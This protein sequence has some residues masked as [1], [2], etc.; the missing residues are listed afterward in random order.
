MEKNG[1]SKQ[2]KRSLPESK[3]SDDV[4]RTTRPR[5]AAAC[6]DFKEKSLRFSEKSDTIETKKQQVVEDEFLALG[7]TTLP[8]DDPSRSTRRLTDFILHDSHGVSQPVEMLEITD[9]FISGVILPSDECSDK[10]KEKGVRCQSFGRV[11]HWSISGYEDGSPVIWISTEL[12]DYDCRKPNASYKKIYD[13]FFLKA[14][15]SIAVYKRLSKSAGGDPDTSLEELLAAVV[16]SMID[17]KYFSSS[18]AVQDFVIVQGEFIYNQLAGLDETAKKHETNFAEI[19]V[20][21]IL[22]DENSRLDK[23]VQMEGNPSNGSL[24]IDGVSQVAEGET[25]TTD[26]LVDGADEDR[27][28]A[29][30][31]QDEEYRKS[32]QRPRKNSSTASASKNVYIKIDED[33]IANDYPLPSYYKTSKEETDELLLSDAGYEVDP[34][35]LPRRTL[36]NWALYNSDSRLISLE[37][38]PTKACDN[39]DVTIFGS[40]VVTDDDGIWFSLDDTGSAMGSGSDPDGMNIFLSQI[41]EWM[42][43]FGGEFIGISLRTDMA[44][45]RLGKPLKHYAPWFEPVLKSA[46]VGISIIT[47]LED[48]T[49]VAK[50]LFPEIMKRLSVVQKT[51]KA[52]ISSDSRT[53]ERYVVA[54]GQIISLVF[55]VYPKEKIRRS[56]FVTELASKMEQRNHTRWNIKKKK[57]LQKGLNLNP[58]AAMAP[59]VSKRKAMRAT[60]TCL[61]NRIWGEYFSI[62]SPEDS[63]QEIAA[64]NGEEEIEEEG[65]NEEDDN[66]DAEDTVP[67]PVEVQKSRTPKKIR[68]S[69]EEMEIKWDGVILGKTSAGEPLYG[70]ALVGGEVVAVGGAVILEIDDPNEFPAIYF[71]EYMFES[72]DHC[73]MLHGRLL[74]R[75]SE[76]VL[77]NAA[78]E[79]ELFLTNECMTVQLKDLKG[80]VSF[81]IRSR[82]WGHQYRKESITEDKLDRARAKERKAKDLPIEYFC[83]SLYSPERGG[84]FSLPLNDIGRGS[85]FCN[86]CKIREDEDE[87]AKIKLNVSKTGFSSNGIEYSAEDFVYVNPNFITIDGLKDSRS[88]FKSGQNIGLRAFVICQLLEIIPNESK[89]AELGSFEVKVRRFYRPED[90][91]EDK[92]YTSDIQEVYYSQDTNVLLPGALEGKCEVRKKID[93]PLRREYPISDHIFFCELFYDSSNGSLK[94]LPANMKLKFST[95]KDDTLLR[96]KKGKGVES[97]TDSGIVKPD[98]VPKEMRLAT[99]DIFAGCGGLSHGLKMAGVSDTKWAIEYEEPAGQAFRQN[100]PE[101]TVFVDNCNVIL[102]AIME[103][104]GDQDE[105]ISTKEANELAAKL[106]EDQKSTLPLPG[107][108]DFINGGP[109]CQ[110]FSGMNRFNESSWSKVQCEMILAFLSFAD[111]FRPRYFLLENVRTFVSFNKGQTFQLTVASLLEMG[112]QVRFGILEAGAYGISQARKRAFIWAAAPEEV[113]PEWP[114]PM[115]V[116]GVPKLNISLSR[117]L[118]YSAVRSTALGAPFRSITV[119]DTIGDLPTVE[120]GDSKT[121]KE[122]QA[123]PVSWYQKEIRGSMIALTDHICKG[124]NELNLIRCKKIPKRPGADWRNLPEEK[125]KLSNGQL[126]DLIPWCLPNTAKRHNQWKGLYGRL[127]WQGNFPTSVTDPQPM[128]KVGMCFHPEQDRIVTVRECARSQGFPDNYEFAGNIIH[129]HRQIGNAVPPPLAFALGRKLKEALLLKNSLQHQP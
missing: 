72:S 76:T 104:G 5:R 2:K 80:T 58:R 63:L 27:R 85:G 17:S 77:G 22:R 49:R 113:L 36:H 119:R 3:E 37:L 86:S 45:Y 81:K 57:I 74:Q 31:L 99:L 9:I 71:V 84:F 6:T 67:E 127:D 35:D 21:V 101:S 39:M 23:A 60:T 40:G 30:L 107:Q 83:K 69:S 103:K 64:E 121:N 59:V 116:F 25:L 114:E 126:E 61:I 54:H 12:A 11:E 13:Y 10:D 118:L 55:G 89:K 108:V 44:W 100:H 109:P 20:L 19:P 105:C 97:E 29:K 95:I 120:N 51:D 110:G 62:D 73:K 18:A 28:Y 53:V 92:A 15:A 46:R 90:V 26:Q 47:L 75:G 56:P 66:E 124:M 96:K 88:S 8:S 42:I 32:M 7:L 111:Y 4:S 128:G 50:L 129:K 48:E 115:H 24:R 14:C 79:R 1:K 41:K 122:Y 33:E 34:D 102:R 98:E 52:Y 91:S 112:Y 82:P 123:D 68:G 94:Q 117:G 43:E 70:Q 106:N 65:G 38:L 16:R 93:M 125:V 78:N 87:R